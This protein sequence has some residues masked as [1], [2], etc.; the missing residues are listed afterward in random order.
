MRVLSCILLL[1]CLAG[2]GND[3]SPP[4]AV[5]ADDRGTQP[6]AAADRDATDAAAPV[7]EIAPKRAVSTQTIAYG[8]A[9]DRNLTGFLALPADSFEPPPGVLVVHEGWGL[10]EST[11]T[12]AQRLAGEGFVVLAVDLYGGAVADSAAQAQELM[13]GVLSNPQPALENIGQG[14]EYLRRYALAPKVAALGWSFGGTWSLQAGLRLGDQL[15]AVV[16]YYG[17]I[18]TSETE[19]KALESPLLGIFA[20]EDQSIPSDSVVQ[21]RSALAKAG[22]SAVVRIYPDARHEFANPASSHYRHA[23]AEAAWAQVIE[24]L[25]AQTG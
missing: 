23:D 21:F 20:G 5:T 15:D 1:A 16:T 4:S 9:G 10:N 19:L 17:Q 12:L 3:A 25:V 8:E 6:N 11:R 7:A 13:T 14:I 22:K 2:C 24:F 18:T